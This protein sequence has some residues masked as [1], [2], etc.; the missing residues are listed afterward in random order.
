MR[1]WMPDL[2]EVRII[3]HPAPGQTLVYMATAAP[4]PFQPR[5]AVTRFER[6]AGNPLTI[7]LQG[8][9]DALP[10]REGFIRIPASSGQWRLL[11]EGNQTLVTYRLRVDP[12]GR[13]PQWLADSAS[14]RRARAAMEAL[15]EYAESPAANRCLPD[16]SDG[17]SR[18]GNVP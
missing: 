9:P 10:R 8:K 14:Q 13:I 11:S 15:K 7:T 2:I 1:Q 17:Q 3:D 4:W 12:G 6:H 5:D 18:H 16:Q